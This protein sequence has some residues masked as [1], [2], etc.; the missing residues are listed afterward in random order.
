MTPTSEYRTLVASVIADESGYV[1]ESDISP[2][3]RLLALG[4]HDAVRLWHLASGREL[5]ALPVGRPLFASNAELLIAGPGGLHRWPIQP[6]EKANQLRLGP[7]RTIALPALPHRAELSRDG[8]M[9]AIVSET[10]AVGLLVDLATNSARALRLHHPNAGFVALSPDAR[11]LATS[12]WHSDRV[13]LWSAQTGEMVKEWMVFRPK[14]FFTPDSRALIVSQDGEVSF[15]DVTTLQRLRWIRRDVAQHPGHVAFSPDGRLMAFEMAPGIIHLK[16]A[17][18]DRTVARLEDP[19]A[20]RAYWMSFTPDGTQLVV[21]T[22]LPIAVHVW[23]LGAIRQRLK[24]MDLDWEWPEF[25]PGKSGEL[26]QRYGEPVWRAHIVA[27][28]PATAT[29][30]KPN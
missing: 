8:R 30:K 20:D 3:G 25:P 19:H 10:E 5:A 27:A 22:H 29:E 28:E 7:P 6:G 18:S 11:W 14:V 24:G 9:L 15:W 4:M 26:G 13:R 12:G 17:A 21:M 1:M 2:D 23:D 16:D